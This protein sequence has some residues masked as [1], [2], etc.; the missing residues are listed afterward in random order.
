MGCAFHGEAKAKDGKHHRKVVPRRSLTDTEVIIPEHWA[1]KAPAPPLKPPFRVVVDCEIDAPEDISWLQS[2]IERSDD[3][4]KHNHRLLIQRV[5]RVQDSNLWTEYEKCIAWIAGVRDREN[6]RSILDEAGA[7][8]DLPL[9]YSASSTEYRSRLRDSVNEVYLWHGTTRKAAESIALHDFK[10]SKD[11]PRHGKKLGRGAYF[12]ESALLADEYAT[13]DDDGLRT[14]LLVRV[15]LGRVMVTTKR[16]SAWSNKVQRVVSTTHLTKSGRWDSVLG[17]RKKAVGTHREYCV[18]D[19]HQLY[20]E[21]LI[22]YKR[23]HDRRPSSS[24]G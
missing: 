24:S 3:S 5:L 7:E 12:A 20:P 8:Q 13:V 14:M 6:L 22:F 23:E 16:N 11:A 2:L 9:T 15:A 1:P 18:A 4:K 21:Y 19:A 10:I 17:D